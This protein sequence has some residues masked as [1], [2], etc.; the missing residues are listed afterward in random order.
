MNHIPCWNTIDPH[1][2]ASSTDQMESFVGRQKELLGLEREA[3]L[4]QTAELLQ[5]NS[6][7]SFIQYMCINL[8]LKS[9]TWT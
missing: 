7:L 1:H 8:K 9:L 4:Q 5:G 2:N 6:S 3:E